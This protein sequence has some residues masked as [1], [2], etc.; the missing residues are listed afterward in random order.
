M[1]SES[2]THT[3][4]KAA[5]ASR[6]LERGFQQLQL[7]FVHM[8]NYQYVSVGQRYIDQDRVTVSAILDNLRELPK[9]RYSNEF[10][11][12]LISTPI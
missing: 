6:T 9:M 11:I 7:D 4:E 2:L 3:T 10:F 1:L 12:V 8:L 5:W